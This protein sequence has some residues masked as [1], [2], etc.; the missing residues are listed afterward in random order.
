MKVDKWSLKA[1]VCSD[2]YR[3]GAQG[4]KPQESLAFDTTSAPLS[5]KQACFPN[6]G[7]YPFCHT[8]YPPPASYEI[9]RSSVTN[10][11]S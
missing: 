9:T 11:P 4:T 8:K 3:V 7:L 2:T 6:V 1:C 10:P 5:A